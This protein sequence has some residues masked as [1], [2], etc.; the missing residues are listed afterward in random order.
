[1]QKK[2]FNLLIISKTLQMQTFLKFVFSIFIE[3]IAPNI[4]AIA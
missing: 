4:A 3:Q 1:M 2:I